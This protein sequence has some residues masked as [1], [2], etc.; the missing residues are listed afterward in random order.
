MIHKDLIKDEVIKSVGE[1]EAG[2]SLGDSSAVKP[3]PRSGTMKGEA[4]RV[5]ELN[6]ILKKGFLGC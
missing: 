4:C 6:R 1:R 3:E 2:T 5:V